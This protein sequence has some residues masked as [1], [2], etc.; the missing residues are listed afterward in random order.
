MTLGTTYNV[1]PI[2]P[3]P[4][5]TVWLDTGGLRVGV[6]YRDLDPQALQDYYTGD[7]LDEIEENSPEGGFTDNGVSIHVVTVAEEHEYLR[8]DMFDDEPHYHYVNKAAGTNTIIGFD[9]AAHGEMLTWLLAELPVRLVPMLEAAGAGHLTATLTA[10]AGDR[11]VGLLRTH[12]AE[13][14]VL[15]GS[16]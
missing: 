8:F 1:Q 6:E 16:S 2:A 14:G 7:D 4:A 12:L 10:D 9:R 15:E 13:I 11:V 3:D 5:H